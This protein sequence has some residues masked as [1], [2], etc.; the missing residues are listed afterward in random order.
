MNNK[1]YFLIVFLNLNFILNSFSQQNPTEDI[2]AVVFHVTDYDSIP[3]GKAKLLITA[4]D[5]N[6]VLN[7]VTD[8][9][10][11]FA[12]LLPEGFQYKISV[13]KFGEDF[14]FERPLD[15]PNI[16]GA[17]KYSKVLKIKLVTEYIRVYKLENVYFDFDKANLKKESFPALEI[18]LKELIQKPA[19]RIEIAGHTDNK[20]SLEYNIRLS[21]QRSDAVV[22]WLVQKGIDNNRLLPKG[23]GETQ[24]V[25]S[26][27]T[28][29]GRTKNRRTEVRIIQ[30]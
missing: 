27:D 24:P 8:V 6:I 5:T 2:A 14:N 19:M 7:G 18:L 4:I 23:Y 16:I 30:E 21:Q 3:E 1:V 15:I 25:A 13:F 10:G 26:N 11:N 9:D 12:A 29:D 17:I 28:E 20:G 22:D